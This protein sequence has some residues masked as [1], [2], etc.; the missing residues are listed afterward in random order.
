MSIEK[1]SNKNKERRVRVWPVPDSSGSLLTKMPCNLC[2]PHFRINF[3]K[4]TLRIGFQ[5]TV[6]MY[7]C[8]PSKC[9]PEAFLV[10]KHHDW[11]SCDSSS[12]T[13]LQ[14]FPKFRAQHQS[15]TAV[16]LPAA[17]TSALEFPRSPLVLTKIW[18][19]TF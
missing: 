11:G 6:F 19:L 14:H 8:V 18:S 15:S 10:L 5:I 12:G 2:L 16:K 1:A 4:T 17:P 13:S 7:C 9:Y 3:N